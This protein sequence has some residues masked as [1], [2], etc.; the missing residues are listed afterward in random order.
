MDRRTPLFLAFLAVG[1]FTSCCPPRTVV[2]GSEWPAPTASLSQQNVN[3]ALYQNASA[4]VAWLYEQGYA[5]ARIK[6]DANMAVPDSL[7]P[8]VIVDVD[9]TVLDN[10]PYEL[11]N[12]LAGRSYSL[13]TWKAW[14]A[15]A[16][17]KALPGAL[18]FLR[19]AASRGCSVYYITN[20]DADEKAATIANLARHGFPMADSAHVWTM[21]GTSDKTA[22]RAA[23][24]QKHRVVLLVGDQLTDF[25]QVLKDRSEGLGLPGMYGSAG[26]LSQYF[27]LLP[28][29]SYGYWRDAI[30]GPGSDAEKLARVRTF[31]QQR[32]R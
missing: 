14:T 15:R 26:E 3:A 27:I 4:E 7:P 32:V 25:D 11:E 2:H 18:E 28:N 10:S 6:L 16:E 29:S 5:F 23:V 31:I 22:R 13:Q 9:E 8:A 20:R 1:T 21:E 24:Q 17:A 30:T 19:Y 12:I